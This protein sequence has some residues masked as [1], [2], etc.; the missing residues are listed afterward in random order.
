MRE[1]VV[2]TISVSVALAVLDAA[3]VVVGTVVVAVVVVAAV[4]VDV[5]VITATNNGSPDRVVPIA[6]TH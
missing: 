3:V 4:V 6:L 1:E 5:S 2:D